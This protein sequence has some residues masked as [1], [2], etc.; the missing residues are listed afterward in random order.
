MHY[1]WLMRKHVIMIYRLVNHHWI[2]APETW[3]YF[4][5]RFWSL[6]ELVFMIKQSSDNNYFDWYCQNKY[7][8]QKR[9]WW[10][11]ESQHT[12]AFGQQGIH[13]RI[14]RKLIHKLFQLIRVKVDRC[15]FSLTAWSIKNRS[16][17]NIEWMTRPERLSNYSNHTLALLVKKKL[18]PAA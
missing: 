8:P 16:L 5:S 10:Y 13:R 11:M 17:K 18:G 15:G 1:V 7:M 6:I 9:G 12:V 4:W 2:M 14:L 3:L